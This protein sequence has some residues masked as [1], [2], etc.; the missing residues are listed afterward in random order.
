MPWDRSQDGIVSSSWKGDGD[1]VP[2]ESYLPLSFH[3]E[4]VDLGR[5]AAF[6]PSEFLSQHGVE[7]VGDHGHDN[8]EVDLN[9]DGGR[10][11]I[12]VKELDGL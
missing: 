8:V 1:L 3:K 5:I 7:G 9:Q 11:G 12:E 4:S 2:R 10:K 6:K